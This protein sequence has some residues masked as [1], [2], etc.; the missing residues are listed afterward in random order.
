[1]GGTEGGEKR[2]EREGGEKGERKKGGETKEGRKERE[3]VMQ[4]TIVSCDQL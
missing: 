4:S 1:M 3:E 2:D